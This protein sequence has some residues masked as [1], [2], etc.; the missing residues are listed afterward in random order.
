MN[1][2]EETQRELIPPGLQSWQLQIIEHL[3]NATSFVPP[4]AGPA[5]SRPLYLLHLLNSEFYNISPTS[6]TTTVSEERLIHG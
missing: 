1:L 5:G 3:T 4:P 2:V 6:S